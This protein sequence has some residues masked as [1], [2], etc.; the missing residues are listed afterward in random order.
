M[1]VIPT[2]TTQ[3]YYDNQYIE[4]PAPDR[5]GM[6]RT[7]EQG[8]C[9]Y[10][11]VDLPNSYDKAKRIFSSDSEETVHLFPPAWILQRG[12]SNITV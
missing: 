8:R 5:R 3:G 1:A 12:G 2:F 10:Y 7:E 4:R 6:V 9:G 11:T